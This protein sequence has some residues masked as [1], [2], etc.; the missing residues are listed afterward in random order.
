VFGL[1]MCA[2][3]LDLVNTST[4]PCL[5]VTN[6]PQ[7]TRTLTIKYDYYYHVPIVIIVT[8]PSRFK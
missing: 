8:S 3:A 1:E 7:A 5:N 6:E 2:R 4:D